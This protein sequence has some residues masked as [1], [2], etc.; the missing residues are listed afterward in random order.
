MS[1]NS[2]HLDFSSEIGF[3]EFVTV[4][5]D[6][7]GRTAGL[8]DEA[9]HRMSVAVTEAVTNA[10]V[11]GNGRDREKRVFAEFVR[12]DDD[13]RG[14]EIRVRDQG[15]GFDPATLADPLAPENLTKPSGRG[16]F[17]MRTLMDE[18]TLQRAAEGGMEIMMVKRIQPF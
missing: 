17:L 18:V 8:D 9:L 4:V 1:E 2:V 6:Y 12:I 15:P 10:I 3:V 13:P 7:F 14:I 16:I 5:S 11:H